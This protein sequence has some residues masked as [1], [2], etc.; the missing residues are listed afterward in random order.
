MA[1]DI[2][3]VLKAREDVL[4]RKNTFKQSF[5][6]VGV[7]FEGRQNIL[8]KYYEEFKRTGKRRNCELILEDD[9]KYD[10]NAIAVMLVS[11]SS[12]EQIGYIAKTE[13]VR[14][15]ES[16][17]HIKEVCV[18]DMGVGQNG[19]IGITISVTFEA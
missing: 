17:E 15:R 9:N 5:Q 10:K 14:L 18:K 2:S 1:I 11:D 16:F 3:K 4:E 13:N 6:V 7:T 8:S 12:F 19:N